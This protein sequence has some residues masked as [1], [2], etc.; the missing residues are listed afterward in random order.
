MVNSRARRRW[1][2]ATIT[3]MLLAV[4]RRGWYW[5]AAT[6][7]ER[8]GERYG[9][10]WLVYNP[11]IFMHWHEKAVESAPIVIDAIERAF[12]QARAYAD[13]GAG[14]GAFSAEL[15]RRGKVA[16]AYERSRWGRLVARTQGVDV[17]GL[18]LEPSSLPNVAAVDVA[19]CFEVAEH[20]PQELGDTLV[21]TCAAMAPSVVFTAAAPGQ[22]GTG[23]INEQPQNYWIERFAEAGM[24]L[25][26]EVTAM[27]VDGFDQAA[28]DWL[29]QNVMAFVNSDSTDIGTGSVTNG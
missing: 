12:P 18:R 26:S 21:R 16:I 22:G 23:H 8:A 29:A 25:D 24:H 6:K 13:V 9:I 3:R 7:L 5:A 2:D 19:L 20:L 4:P 17:R 1:I 28:A 11:L 15:Q 27:L 14:T 10:Q